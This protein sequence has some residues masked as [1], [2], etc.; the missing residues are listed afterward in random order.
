MRSNNTHRRQN[1]AGLRR[2][3]Y[4]ARRFLILSCIAGLLAAA[5]AS[6]VRASIAAEEKCKQDPILGTWVALTT[7]GERKQHLTLVLEERRGDKILGKLNN[8]SYSPNLSPAHPPAACAMPDHIVRFRLTG[9]GALNGDQFFFRTTQLNGTDR[10]CMDPQQ[11]DW[12]YEMDRFKGNL[13]RTAGTIT[14][15]WDDDVYVFH[16]PVVFKRVSCP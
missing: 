10:I 14:V 3:P 6:S 7:H 8:L 16:K 1:D 4:S 5:G 2:R 11:P 15:I 9:E 13:N 12:N